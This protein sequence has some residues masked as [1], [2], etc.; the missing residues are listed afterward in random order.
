MADQKVSALTTIPVVDRAADI[1]YIV[2]TS[3]G[4]SNK[5]TPNTLLGITGAPVG[6]TDV[7]TLT[8]KTITS[9]AI[10]SP[11]FSGTITGTYTIG[12]TPTFPSSVATLTGSQTFTNKTLTSPTINTPTITNPTITVDS[13]SEFTAANGV[14]IDGLNIKDSK[15]NTN[16]SVVTAN[17]TD[18]AVTPAK[19]QSGTGSAWAW[20]SW[21][22]TWVNLTV[23]NATTSYGYTQTGKT[24]KGYIFLSLGSTSSVTGTP[25]FTLPVTANARHALSPRSILG[26][27]TFV[28]TGTATYVG[29]VFSNASTT[30]ATISAIATGSTYAT[31]A[32]VTGS[33]PFG[34]GTGD[35][36]QIMFEYEAA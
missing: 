36:M 28:D 31:E 11:V 4:T 7:A 30:I 13:I 35:T 32:L 16:N 14:T 21:A 26:Q 2:D 23:G 17:I 3:G 22:P 18:T 6:D 8:N 25:T 33:V 5:V 9:P 29:F 34:F 19:L 24:V 27:A 10:S 12:G 15:L 20:Q 1:L